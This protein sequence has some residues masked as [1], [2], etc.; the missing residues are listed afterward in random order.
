MKSN[1][2]LRLEARNALHGNWATSALFCFIY[3]IITGI[4][5]STF[6]LPFGNDVAL[7][8]GGSIVG[9]IICLPMAWGMAVAF[10]RQFNGEEMELG[11]L[12]NGYP[13]ARVWTTK[14]LQYLYIFLWT[15][16]LIIPG[17]VKAYSYGM[18]DYILADNPDMK[19][20]AAI[21]ES[22]RMM[23]GRKMKLFLLDLSFIGWVILACL[24]TLGIGLIWVEAYVQS[25]HAAFYEDAKNEYYGVTE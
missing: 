1:S 19:D 12:F 7:S 5:N 16:L 3:I 22:M 14:C 13:Q 24:F 8:Q 17:I 4:L 9:T 15:L 25:A 23:S 11:W 21:E 18:T 10:R 6:T 20:N 2:E